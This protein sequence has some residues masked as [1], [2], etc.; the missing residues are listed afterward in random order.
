MRSGRLISGM[1]LWAA[2]LAAQTKV[3]PSTVLPAPAS[4]GQSVTIKG[5]F[6]K[7]KSATAVIHLGG[8][9]Q[10]GDPELAGVVGGDGSSVA[11]TLP[12]PLAPGRY[13]LTVSQAGDATEQ[14][15]PGELGVKGAT[16]TLESTHPTTAYRSPVNGG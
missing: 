6:D 4:A 5:T 7:N 14:T 9:P 13:F 16:V 3:D 8:A 15:V 1:M 11:V 2:A 10:P 12:S